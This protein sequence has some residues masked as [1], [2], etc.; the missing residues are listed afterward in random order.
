MG[1]YPD[2]E[3]S[4]YKIGAATEDPITIYSQ[5]YGQLDLVGIDDNEVQQATQHYANLHR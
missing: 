4:D 5:I 1:I 2:P 3:W